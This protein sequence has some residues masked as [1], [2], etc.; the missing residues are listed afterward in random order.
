MQIK[1]YKNFFLLT[2][3]EAGTDEA[4]SNRPYNEAFFEITPLPVTYNARKWLRQ[5]KD[6]EVEVMT[7]DELRKAG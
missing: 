6:A 2:P 3:K 7:L 5:R 4:D 1:Q